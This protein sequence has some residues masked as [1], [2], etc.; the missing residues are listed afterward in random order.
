[1]R[2]RDLLQRVVE[3]TWP[4]DWDPGHRALAMTVVLLFAPVVLGTQL[5]DGSVR[6]GHGI[7]LAMAESALG[8]VLCAVPIAIAIAAAYVGAVLSLYRRNPG[9]RVD[10][11][12]AKATR[13]RK[14]VLRRVLDRQ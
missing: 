13:R 3:A 14:E 8:V 11:D 10:R 7:G 6:W 12:Q 2:C 5:I 9:W 4:R 1:M